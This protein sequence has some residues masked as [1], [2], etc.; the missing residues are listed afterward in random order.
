MFQFWYLSNESTLRESQGRC[1]YCTI[2]K[3]KDGIHGPFLIKSFL[4][5][6]YYAIRAVAVHSNAI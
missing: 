2:V 4:P 3:L 1:V 5:L 6:H